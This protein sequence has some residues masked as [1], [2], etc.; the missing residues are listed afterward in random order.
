MSKLGQNTGRAASIGAIGTAGAA[1]LA[2][3]TYL[4]AGKEADIEVCLKADVPFVEGMTAGCYS[5]KELSAFSNK[6]VFNAKGAP[7]VISLAHPTDDLQGLSIARSCSEY[8]RLRA[9]EYFPMSSREIRREQ[10]FKR[11]CG[12]LRLLLD[13]REA[14]ENFFAGSA[15]SQAEMTSLAEG[16]PFRMA[17][18]LEIEDVSAALTKTEDGKW[19]MET[20]GQFATFQEI[21]F[22]DFN[23]DGIGDFLVF[24]SIN[25]RAATAQTGRIG[26][27][28]KAAPDAEITFTDIE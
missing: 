26:L 16:P 17:E 18:A 25:V 28:E 6:P 21:A 7:L 20:E 5:K 23:R 27:I 15:M 24:V 14:K 2:G 1:F 9:S 3:A 10:Y 12:T 11:A 4:Y 22:A 8:D 19:R 13:S